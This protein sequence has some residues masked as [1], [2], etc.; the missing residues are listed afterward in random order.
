MLDARFLTNFGQSL[1]RGFFECVA[2]V[3]AGAEYLD[4]C[5]LLG[6]GSIAFAAAAAGFF[7]FAKSK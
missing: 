1:E 4:R 6:S 7:L 3:A 2:L 5:L